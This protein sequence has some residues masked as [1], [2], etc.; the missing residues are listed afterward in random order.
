V[1]A[2]SLIELLLVLGLAA[3]LSVI[4]VPQFSGALNDM[5]TYAAVRLLSS[6]LQEARMQAIARA[7]DTAVRIAQAGATYTITTYVDGNATGVRSSDIAGGIDFRIRASET[8]AHHFRDVDF[9]AIAGLPAVDPG[10]TPPGSDPVRLGSGNMVTFTPLGTATPGSLYIRGP[11]NVQYVIRVVGET[12]R[13]RILKFNRWTRTW[14]P[15]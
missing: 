4:A 2:F 7:R 6:R 8:L 9:G 15:L 10:G 1:A 12:G 14:K 13:T 3:T 11:G 5:R